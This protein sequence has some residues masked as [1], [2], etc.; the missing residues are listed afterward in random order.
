MML[1]E[2]QLNV[3]ISD[4]FQKMERDKADE[5]YP[6]DKKPQIILEDGGTHRFC[7]FSLLEAQPLIDNQV[8]DAIWIISKVVTSLYP[9]CMLDKPQLIECQNGASGW[10]SYRSAGTEGELFNVMY[11]FPVNSCMMLGTIGCMVEDKTGK[12]W[13]MELMA[14]LK[15]FKKNFS[16]VL[17]GK[18]GKFYEKGEFRR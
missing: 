5:M 6:Y 9:S 18:G 12:K 16:W 3:D 10:F 13:M 8:E 14:S 2:E 11:I 17:N 7:T 4:S 15:A 1:F